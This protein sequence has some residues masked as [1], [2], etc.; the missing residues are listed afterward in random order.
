[1]TKGSWMLAVVVVAAA[2]LAALPGCRTEVIC[3]AGQ[4]ACGES[5]RSFQ[6][7]PANCGAC[8][9]TCA[10]GEVCSAGNCSLCAASCTSARGCVNEVCLPDLEVACYA[11]GAVQALA[12]DLSPV[13]PPRA[14]DGGPVALAPLDGRTWVAHSYPSPTIRSVDLAG[15][16]SPS[17]PLGGGDLEMVRAHAGAYGRPGALLYVSDVT[18]STL[19][20][21]DPAAALAGAAGAVVDEVD[22]HRVAANGENPKGIAFAGGKAYVALYGDAFLGDYAHGQAVSVV[23]LPTAACATPPCATVLKTISLQGVPG[24]ADAPGL[25]FPSGAVA[26]GSSVYVTLANLKLGGGYYGTPA[27]PGKLLVVDTAAGDALSVVQLPG[28][29]NPG[30]IAAAGTRLWIACGGTG[31]AM[32]VDLSGPVPVPAAPV[33]TGVTSGGIAICNGMGYVT[34]QWSGT[35]VRFDPAGAL[36]NL[37]MPGVCPVY[38]PGTGFAW[39]ADV[40]CAP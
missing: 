8:G 22:L 10:A 5:C 39:A 6:T 33:A 21:V 34:D 37:T 4:T 27:G 16:V 7:D 1:M 38:P 2:A 32:P 36:P 11:S 18:P 20:V 3:P 15:A 12:G 13:G 17:L 35:V 19:V 25:P 9:H 30:A 26:V 40:A 23:Q 14:V 31:A 28:C 24:A 29:E